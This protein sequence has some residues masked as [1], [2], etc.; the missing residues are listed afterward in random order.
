MFSTVWRTETLIFKGLFYLDVTIFRLI[1]NGPDI[2]KPNSTDVTSYSF[3]LSH[4]VNYME[5]TLK[6]MY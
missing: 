5:F 3:E 1:T 4:Y 2:Y 6:L